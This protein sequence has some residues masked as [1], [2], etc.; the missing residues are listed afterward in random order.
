MVAR[1]YEVCARY[2]R[3]ASTVFIISEAD[4][5]KQLLRRL[6]QDSD[7]DWRW[8]RSD[9]ENPDYRLLTNAEER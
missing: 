1:E 8:V 3:E 2:A 5:S 7:D 9:D 6:A 4:Y